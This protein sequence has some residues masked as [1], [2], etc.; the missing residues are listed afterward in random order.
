MHDFDLSV[1]EAEI[2]SAMLAA[3]YARLPAWLDAMLAAGLSP[4]E[5]TALAR[6]ALVVQL[7]EIERS[8]PLAARDQLIT[9]GAASLH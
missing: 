3:F 9:A 1:D 8:A 5:A 7:A 6:A 4:D 2:G